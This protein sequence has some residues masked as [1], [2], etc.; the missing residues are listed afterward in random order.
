MVHPVVVG[1]W[2]VGHEKRG[3]VRT[4]GIAGGDEE[5]VV[6]ALF[7][8][9]FSPSYSLKPLTQCPKLSVLRCPGI[10][11]RPGCP[12]LGGIK[13]KQLCAKVNR[14]CIWSQTNPV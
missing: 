7:C 13:E 10:R 5:M 11:G 3:E 12:E 1:Q 4:G 2:G 14:T 8:L 6:E 9:L